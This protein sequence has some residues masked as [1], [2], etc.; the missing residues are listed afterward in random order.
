MLLL[1]NW[2]WTFSGL[3]TAEHFDYWLSRLKLFEP[4]SKIITKAT[5]ILKRGF[6]FYE[7]WGLGMIPTLQMPMGLRMQALLSKGLPPSPVPLPSPSLWHQWRLLPDVTQGWRS[8]SCCSC[9]ACSRDWVAHDNAAVFVAWGSSTTPRLFSRGT[10]AFSS[11][12]RMRIASSRIF[13]LWHILLPFW[14][15]MDSQ[16]CFQASP[17]QLHRPGWGCLSHLCG[18]GGAG[19]SFQRVSSI[20]SL[21]P[22]TEA[23]E[24]TETVATSF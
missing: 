15:G 14:C 3:Q 21:V 11:E 8:S 5:Y 18:S 19:M 10:T 7:D 23:L 20:C 2:S 16:L 1:G 24:R 12:P 17:A 9:T 4:D 13:A 22:L 6:Q